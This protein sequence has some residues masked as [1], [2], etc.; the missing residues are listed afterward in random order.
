MAIAEMKKFNLVAMSYDKD[1]L[2][3][4][5]QRTGAVE[6]KEHGAAEHTVVPAPD[7][8]E[9]RALFAR[10]EE[11]LGKLLSASREYERKNKIRPTEPKDGFEVSYDEFM[12]AGSAAGETEALLARID[13]LAA[14]KSELEGERTA[15]EREIAAATAYSRLGVPFSAFSGT[16]HTSARLGKIPLSRR[17]KLTETL[18]G[19]P[20]VDFGTETEGEDCLLWAFFHKSAAGEAEG[21]LAAANFEACPFKGAVTGREY[22]ASLLAK[23]RDVERDIQA[24]EYAMYELNDRIRPLK[25]YCDYLGFQLEKAELAEK[26]RVTER[27]F[28]LEA[29]VPA[30][31]EEAVRKAVLSVTEAAYFGFSDPAPDE[32]PPTLLKNNSVVANFEPITNMYS[33]PNVR[34]FDPNAVMAFF[35]SLFMGFIIG[36]MGYGLVMLLGG[37]AVYFRIKDRASGLKRLAGVFAIGGI[38]SVGWGILFNSLFGI[39]LPF[40]RTVMPNPQEDMWTFVGISVPA[41]LFISL[42]IG[43]FQLLVGYFCRAVQEWRRGHFWD[44][45]WD[46]LVWAAF[47]LGAGLAF[48]GLL[49][50]A[51][52]PALAQAG[53]I[54]AGVSLLLAMLTAGRKEKAAGKFTKG[55]GAVY[56]IINY[57][58]D[59]LSYARLYGLMLSGAVI[60]QIVSQYAVGFITGGN[61]ALAV[62]G[63]VLMLAGHGFNLVMNLLG[64]Y[65]HDARLQYVEFY[66]KFFEGEGELFAPL[67]SRHRHIRLSPAA[68]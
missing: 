60:A 55:F 18:S 48:V 9:I 50:E 1:A 12:A 57:A 6:V 52:I 15:V 54:L 30:G 41:V 20:L 36:D 68:F 61:P 4:A 67:G 28:L 17:E 63:V 32:T 64:A 16:A 5:L 38:F 22:Y 59:I 34:E 29:Y 23:K 40:L 8:E 7:A 51:G 24:N 21:A 66:G 56:G 43:V 35:Y 27:T 45:V 47:S 10:A 31:A 53:G 3:D 65:I 26:L 44:G 25:V 39:S 37:G 62:L 14:E 33:V 11:G 46:G 13:R 49:E 42:L 19:I 58:S 2:L